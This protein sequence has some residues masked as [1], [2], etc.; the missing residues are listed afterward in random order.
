MFSQIKNDP[1]PLSL[2]RTHLPITLYVPMVPGGDENLLH[3][4]CSVALGRLSISYIP[5]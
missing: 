5:V 1:P 3:V 4:L 2:V